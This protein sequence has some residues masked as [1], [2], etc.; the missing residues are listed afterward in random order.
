MVDLPGHLGLAQV[1]RHVGD[2]SGA[3]AAAFRFG[4]FPAPNTLFYVLA[5]ALMGP[6]GPI[7]ASKVI[8]GAYVVGM[9]LSTFALLRALG[10]SGV[11]SLCAFPLSLHWPLIEGFIDY[12][13]SVPLAFLGW[14]LLA[15]LARGARDRWRTRRRTQLLIVVSGLVFLAHLEGAILYLLG[16]ALGVALA[17]SRTGFARALGLASASVGPPTLLAGVWL[18]LCRLRG[19]HPGGLFPIWQN[20]DDRLFGSAR[21]SYLFL[22]GPRDGWLVYTHVGALLLAAAVAPPARPLARPLFALMAIVWGVYAISPLSIGL[23]WNF[24]N[25]LPAFLALLCPVLLAAARRTHPP[26]RATAAAIFLCDALYTAT[27]WSVPVDQFAGWVDGMLGVLA[28]APKGTRLAFYPQAT[29]GSGFENPVW[30]HLG[31][32]HMALNEGLT[33]YTFAD[34]GGRIVV[35]QKLGS[36]F[37]YLEAAQLEDEAVLQRYDLVLQR[38]RDPLAKERFELLQ[39]T[40]AWALYRVRH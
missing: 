5:A 7:A 20:A 27:C 33:S 8:L 38:G 25:R 10:R 17:T 23:Y 1:L 18:A 22:E 11:W 15:S 30:R 26:L 2:P 13:L 9:P 35:Q 6:L 14:A 29:G 39:R 3:M 37:E 36:D 34:H 32:Y 40:G 31:A 12:A 21:F 16:A 19:E 4:V 28:A 24:D